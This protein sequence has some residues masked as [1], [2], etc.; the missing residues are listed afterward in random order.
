MWATFS[1][2]STD[3]RAVQRGVSVWSSFLIMLIC[4]GQYSCALIC[5]G[6]TPGRGIGC[7]AMVVG[8]VT[9]MPQRF[10]NDSIRPLFDSNAEYR[11][12]PGSN[13]TNVRRP[14]KR[15]VF[16]AATANAS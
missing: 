8:K 5:D 12:D 7:G 9:S 4:D 15:L 11:S 1:D 10:L 16:G 13:A 2:V 14:A 6:V 3:A